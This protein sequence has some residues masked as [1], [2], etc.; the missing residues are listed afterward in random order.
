MTRSLSRLATAC[1]PALL[2]GSATAAA[3]LLPDFSAA[4]FQPGR[5]IDNPY[6]PVIPRQRVVL[7]ASGVDDEGEPFTEKSILTGL[8]GGP[9]ISGV[10][11][12]TLVDLA[13]EDGLLVEK[14]HDYYAQDDD[15]NVWYLGEDVTNYVYD[16][17]GT[18]L[19]TNSASSWIAGVNGALPGFIMPAAPQPGFTYFQEFA[20][21]D[22]AL[23]EAEIHAV[24]LDLSIG[25]GDFSQV[26]AIREG[27]QLDPTAR[28]IKYYA[29]GIGIIRADEGLDIGLSNPEL[30]FELTSIAPVPLPPA[31]PV[32]GSALAAMGWLG[33]RKLA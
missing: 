22:G 1:L 11:S 31:L 21:A 30:V 12:R 32:L 17:N 15:G 27:T 24:G 13:Y 16:D 23:D 6:F 26:I 4:E 20:A 29:P 33:R 14:T 18:L 10:Q 5:P 9:V 28:E 2:L 7:T 8:K 3:P 25:Y 19:S